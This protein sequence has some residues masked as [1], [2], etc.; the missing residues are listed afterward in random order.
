MSEERDIFEVMYTNRAVRQFTPEPVPDELIQRVLEAATRA[1]NGSNAQ[2]WRFLVLRDP[3]VRA[4][5]GAYYNDA[6]YN[7]YR[8]SRISQ[9]AEPNVAR[10]ANHL[11]DH[12]GDEPPVLI[13]VCMERSAG[14][15][16][17]SRTSGSS[18]FPAVQNLML[19]AR[20]LGLGTCLT[21]VHQHREAEIKEYLGIPDGV[22][23]YA[24]IPIGYPATK[25]GPLTRNPV[26]EVTHYD[27]WGE[28]Q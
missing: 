4:R 8:P 12:M 3:E 23:T 10:P 11:A 16:P 19:A 27:R 21:T 26:S 24:L 20:A 14:G 22:D 1:P 6:F 17:P 15:D 18:I 28:S 5:V 13:L 2:R 9:I 7:A 25:F